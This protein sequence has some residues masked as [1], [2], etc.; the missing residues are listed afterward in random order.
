MGLGNI[1]NISPN[2]EGSNALVEAETQDEIEQIMS[3]I[4]SLQKDMAEASSVESTPSVVSTSRATPAAEETPEVPEVDASI[5][6]LTGDDTESE[7]IFAVGGSDTPSNGSAS[8]DEVPL[9]ETLGSMKAEESETS[10]FDDEEDTSQAPAAH[11]GDHISEEEEQL[12]REINEKVQMDSPVS[13][14]R[15]MPSSMEMDSDR[16]T[17]PNGSGGTGALTLSLVGNMNLKLKYESEGHEVL[18]SFA[19]EALRVQ[20]EDGTEFKIPM[21]RRARNRVA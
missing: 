20:L 16:V 21:G 15:K 6:A 8:S 5:Q 13:P 12:I 17:A 7:P 1:K 3:E 2:G 11:V 18:I 10:I 19:D 4:E 9:E 14:A